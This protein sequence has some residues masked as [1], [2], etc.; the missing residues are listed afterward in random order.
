MHFPT[1]M[2]THRCGVLREDDIGQ[3]VRLCGW[4]QKVRDLGG[5]IF[6]DLRDRSGV[7]QVVFREE[8]I[9]DAM[10]RAAHLKS[11]TVIA[12]EGEV[13]R[14][15]EDTVNPAIPTGHIEVVVRTLEILNETETLPFQVQDETTAGEV[16]RLR[17]RYLDL[18]RPIMQRHLELRH[19]VLLTARTFLHDE[20][21]LEIET[22]ILTRSTPE[23]ARD[24]LV[25]S[26]LYP[27]RFYA[28]PQSPQLFKQIL[29][30]AGYD[31]YF[32]IARCFRDED[33]R[34]DRQPEFTQIDIEMSFVTEDDVMNLTEA[35]LVRMFEVAGITLPQPFPRMTFR[36]ALE[37]YGSDRPD[38]RYPHPLVRLDDVFMDSEFKI[39]KSAAVEEGSIVLGLRVPDAAGWARNRLDQLT[40]YVKQLGAP[41]IL[42]FKWPKGDAVQSP[43]ARFLS[44]DEIDQMMAT[45]GCTEGDLLLVMAGTWEETCLRMG[46]VREWVAQKEKWIPSEDRWCPVWIVEFPLLEWDADE[47]RWVARHHPFTQ[48]A[49]PDFAER[50]PATVKARAYDIVLNGVEI[51]GGSIRN[52]RMDVQMK[53]FDLL[54]IPEA[55][56][57]EKFGFLLDALRYGAPPH[58][59]IA[60]GVDR[61]IMMMAGASS[62]RDVIAFPKTASGQCLMTGSPAEVEERQLKEL[63]IQVKK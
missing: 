1:S 35:L 14:R 39:L 36:D 60:L 13:V 33:L 25:P 43:V 34:A 29:M 24:F 15:S 18:R 3:T 26:R 58:G 2:R 57:R 23:G 31:R 6:V 47:E 56:A 63:H 4:V 32:Q 19:R 9:P 22:P 38:L 37:Q 21:F 55:E 51:G 27:G 20:G 5:V 7:I 61:I 53:I 17:Y 28:L 16:I 30:V 11:E 40:D 44:P 8:I 49:E 46:A 59:G 45:A 42:W 41:G 54:R 10:D 62:I 50:D 12:V 52:H 48:P